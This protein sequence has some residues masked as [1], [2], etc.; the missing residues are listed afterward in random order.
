[1]KEKDCTIHIGIS[2]HGQSTVGILLIRK[3]HF[4]SESRHNIAKY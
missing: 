4:P 1:M 3:N 2:P